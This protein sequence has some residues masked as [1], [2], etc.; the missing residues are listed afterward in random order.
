MTQDSTTPPGFERIVDVR[1]SPQPVI[2]PETAPFWDGLE[3]GQFRVQ[4]CGRCGT[5]RFP[6]APV[7]FRCQ[8]FELQWEPVDPAGMVASAVTVHRATG[9]PEWA[10]HVPFLSGTVDM[11]HGLRVP[12]QIL[13]SCG[14][15]TLRGAPV[16][17]VLLTGPQRTTVHAFAHACIPTGNT[18]AG[19]PVSPSVRRR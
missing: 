4:V 16:R 3:I 10:A 6:F 2:H 19:S 12:G 11:E 15:A 5:H 1:P 9:D 17:V 13:C 8:S 7:C 14:K 18:Q